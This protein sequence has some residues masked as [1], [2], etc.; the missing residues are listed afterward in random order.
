[1]EWTKNR[2]T[3]NVGQVLSLLRATRAYGRRNEQQV[4]AVETFAMKHIRDSTYM[5]ATA[6]AIETEKLE[7]CLCAWK[8]L[9]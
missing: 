8:G 9:R 2:R 3:K 4:D 1:M 5:F 6:V 7:A